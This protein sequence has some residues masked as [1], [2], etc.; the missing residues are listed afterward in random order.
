MKKING[1]LMSEDECYQEHYRLIYHALRPFLYGDTGVDPEDLIS[2]GKIGFIKAYRNFD[3]SLGYKFSSYAIRII[4]FEAMRYI[5]DKGK[6]VKHPRTAIELANRINAAGLEEFSL[7][8]IAVKFNTSEKDV[9]IALETMK[10]VDSL[11]ASVFQDSEKVTMLDQLGNEEDFTAV[12]VK[13]FLE[14]LNGDERQII[15]MR[16]ED[17]TQREIGNAVGV[18]QIQISRKLK[19]IG[20]KYLEYVV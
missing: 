5:R 6:S 7:K 17:R 16:L 10:V 20:E 15:N 14:S 18:S 2:E 13:D 11:N 3:D 19:S 8:D 9:E 12:Y 1:I 4:K